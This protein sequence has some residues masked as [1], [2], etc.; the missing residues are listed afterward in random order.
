M[1]PQSKPSSS[2]DG[3]LKVDRP[4]VDAIGQALQVKPPPGG[5]KA[6]EASLKQANA[7]KKAERGS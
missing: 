1:K 2:Q 3:P 7:K 5:W 4:F 6:Y